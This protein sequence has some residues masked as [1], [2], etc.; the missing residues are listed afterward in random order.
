MKYILFKLEDNQILAFIQEYFQYY[1][2]DIVVWNVP[3]QH[4]SVQF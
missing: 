3:K 1:F 2:V 4:S